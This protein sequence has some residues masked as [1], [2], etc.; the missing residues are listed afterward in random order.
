MMIEQQLLP[1]FHVP[2]YRTQMGAAYCADSLDLLAALPEESIDLVMT[3]P[4]S[5]CCARRPMGIAPRKTMWL[6]SPSVVGAHGGAIL[7]EGHVAD[8]V[9]AILN[10]RIATAC[11]QLRKVHGASP[12]C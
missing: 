8:I 6:G 10:D 9:Q 2:A 11:R 12:K 3:S 5:R 7:V 1:E 4:P